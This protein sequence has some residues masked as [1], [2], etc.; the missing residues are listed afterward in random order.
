MRL[1]EPVQYR[2]AK[3][4]ALF[5][6]AGLAIRA[7]S[8]RRIALMDPAAKIH[9]KLMRPG[10]LDSIEAKRAPL[11]QGCLP[12]SSPTALTHFLVTRMRIAALRGLSSAVLFLDLTAAYYRLIR[13]AVVEAEIDDETLCALLSRLQVAPE[14]VHEVEAFV[15][16]GGLLPPASPHFRRALAMMYRHTFF[17][18]DGVQELTVTKVGSRP[19]DAIS[20]TMF[21][22]AAT[23]LLQEVGE[24]LSGEGLPSTAVP[25]WADDLALPIYAPASSLETA[26]EF[27][28][29]TLHQ[30][31]LK[32]AM[33]PNYAA[34]KTEALVSLSGPKAQLVGRRL[35]K[36]GAGE[37]VLQVNPAVRLRCVFQYKHLGTTLTAKTR[38][39]KDLKLKLGAAQ[40]AAAPLAKPVL[41]RRDVSQNCRVQLLDTLAYSRASYGSAIWGTLD[42]TTS[43]LWQAGVAALYRNIIRP[44]ITEH[45]PVFPELAALC[46]QVD[47]PLPCFSWRLLLLE[48]LKMLGALQQTAV[49]DALQEEAGLTAESWW[50]A[51]DAAVQWLDSL[52]QGR[53]RYNAYGSAVAFLE[54]AIHA[55]HKVGG[56]IRRA[57]RLAVRLTGDVAEAATHA[58][59]ASKAFQCEDCTERFDALQQVRAHAWSKH[60]GQTVLA[61]LAPEHTCSSCLVCF[62]RRS[63]LLRHI[64]HDS[65]S[66]GHRLLA[67]A[68]HSRAPRPP[69]KREAD[70]ASAYLP[71]VRVSG[72][73]P[74]YC[75]DLVSGEQLAKFCELGLLG[76]ESSE[77]DFAA[78]ARRSLSEWQLAST[79]TRDAVFASLS[80]HQ[81]LVF[82]A[83]LQAA[84]LD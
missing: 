36:T 28:G 59:P 84:R 35:F 27:T 78:A 76:S 68:T 47:R 22:L 53:P 3:L 32:R 7:E 80:V 75:P 69:A 56:Q 21:A 9:H 70:S 58:G 24:R 67:V 18:M 71:A 15:L 39:A 52:C 17:V 14:Q 4:S 5:K 77:D 23:G 72:P 66:C 48:H 63:R 81:T 51:A 33:C 42:V 43:Q 16:K 12:N 40:G 30:A 13:E 50:A 41:R 62:W 10:L 54:E 45:G 2:G 44:R 79:D 31:C 61:K 34:G 65:P 73:P 83:T 64:H 49:V 38:P 6:K 57:K 26:I 20:D 74:P 46:R 82:M 55:A 25:T 29:R 1:T 11:Q 8:F 60:R 37:V 19:G